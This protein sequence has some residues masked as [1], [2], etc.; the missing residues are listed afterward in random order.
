[1]AMITVYIDD[2]AYKIE[3]MGKNLLEVCLS[4]KLNLPYFCWHPAL[5]SVGACR[6]CAVKLLKDENDKKGR[7][8]MACM[9]PVK[10]GLRASINDPEAIAFRAQIIEWLMMN[11]PHDCP[12]CDEGGECHLQDMTV[13]TGHAYRRYRFDKRTFQNQDLGP[14]VNQEMN[15]CIECY[16]CVRFYRDYAGGRD[17]NVFGW[18]DLLFFGR[19]EDGILESPF[20]GN[21]V[22]V[23]PTGVFTDKT[24]K[25][26]YTRKWDLSSAPS[27]CP[28]CSLGCNT[29]PGEREGVVRRI[30]N[31]YH[32]EINGYFLCDRGRYGYEYLNSP[33][34]LLTPCVKNTNHK[35]EETSLETALNS[36]PKSGLVGIGSPRASL[37]SNFALRELV[38]AENFYHGVSEKEFSSVKAIIDIVQRNPEQTPTLR[39]TEN[40][41]AVVILGE[42]LAN[43]SPLLALA[44]HQAVLQQPKAQAH[45]LHIPEW[46]D[47]ALRE[48]IQEER[49][50]LF[51]AACGPTFLD[52]IASDA[53][54]APPD[55]IARLGF[56]VAHELDPK[57][58][59]PKDLRQEIKEKA[60]RIASAL[61]SAQN[62]LIIS[63]TFSGSL[64][65]IHA[66]ANIGLALSKARLLFTLPACNSFGLGL[67]Q[68][69]SFEALAMKEIETLIILE[70][71]LYRHIDEAKVQA[72]IRK[73]KK[74]VVIDH[75]VSRTTTAAD[76]LLPK[77]SVMEEDGTFVN[78][79]GRA[80]RF[81][82]VL[83]EGKTVASWRLCNMLFS[84]RLSADHWL[85]FD[86][87]WEDLI[88]KI[89]LFS[90]LMALAPDASFRMAGQKIPRE[91]AR[92]SGRTALHA[93]ENLHEQ[94]P[95]EDEDSPLAFSMEG[96]PNQPPA[97]LIPRY[98]TPGWNSVQAVNAYQTVINGPYPE[99]GPGMRFIEQ[100]GAAS[101]FDQIP[102]H[103]QPRSGE[104][105]L[106]PSFHI[107]GSEELSSCGRA[108]SSLVPSPYL[109]I[110]SE[111]GTLL[112][113]TDGQ[114]VQ[115][116]IP[117]GELTL[118][119]HAKVP[120]GIAL[121]PWGLP[122]F[123]L[124]E[125]PQWATI[126]S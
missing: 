6:Q 22:E 42:D 121:I 79:E 105:L 64:E 55:E 28:H 1:M 63:G 112:G 103:F 65:V 8:V 123:V 75:V 114:K 110:N 17:F 100:R 11:H 57:A 29:L 56:Q 44:M 104:W 2:T 10:D 23:C 51:I 16:R 77:P 93:H 108:I 68:G 24:Q 5:R 38:G 84:P 125:T 89:P 61:R 98:W 39:E 43:T 36:I 21:L 83:P 54:C 86:T 58:P 34:R 81:Y 53:F 4:L 95:P 12:V 7:L 126:K 9:T 14:F 118:R 82:K 30:R 52:D 15:R 80:Q 85:H 60:I 13:M 3:D 66:A 69:K 101:Y 33:K 72:L 46:D 124:I 47:G 40:A 78:N 113:F 119:L 107:F 26:H 37:E 41:D 25:E 116:S 70:N 62:P 88:K 73:A 49:G 122:G 45:S 31:R 109:T 35:L 120:E 99:K 50:P 71:D 96:T 117:A 19:H 87:L 94:K 97:A 92:C 74:V 76:V 27:I 102:P 115:L 18:H 59:E 48:V 111:Q 20:S 106:L 67:M 32:P 91:P 90:P